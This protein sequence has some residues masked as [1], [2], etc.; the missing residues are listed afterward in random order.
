MSCR[1]SA[2]AFGGPAHQVNCSGDPLVLLAPIVHEKSVTPLQPF[3]DESVF[4]VS[5]SFSN[6]RSAFKSDFG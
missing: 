2:W 5:S 6:E 1:Q 3:G 4:D